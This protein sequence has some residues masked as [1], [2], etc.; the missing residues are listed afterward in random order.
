MA[1]VTC[2]RCGRPMKQ[3]EY[4]VSMWYHTTEGDFDHWN[5]PGVFLGGVKKLVHRSL[6]R[7]GQE[8]PD[9]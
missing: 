5:Y 6:K 2:A 1:D 7:C 9:G 4:K 3:G 8:A